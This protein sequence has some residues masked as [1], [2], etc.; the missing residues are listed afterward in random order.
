MNINQIDNILKLTGCDQL[1]SLGRS[2]KLLSELPYSQ[3]FLIY[4]DKSLNRRLS[5][6]EIRELKLMDILNLTQD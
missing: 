1:G 5:K 6:Q 3:V 2:G 4:K